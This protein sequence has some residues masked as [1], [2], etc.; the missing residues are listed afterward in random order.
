M[1]T[2]KLYREHGSPTHALVPIRSRESEPWVKFFSQRMYKHI[3]S[4]RADNPYLA[5]FVA[6]TFSMGRDNRFFG[7]QV[8]LAAEMQLSASTLSRGLRRLAELGFIRAVHPANGHPGWF[9]NPYFVFS[10]TPQQRR[11]AL[12]AWNE[13]PEQ[14]GFFQ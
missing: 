6:L 4:E 7:T 13:V 2:E 1:R 8:G 10:G 5:I 3:V 14:G 9:V 11:A 12:S